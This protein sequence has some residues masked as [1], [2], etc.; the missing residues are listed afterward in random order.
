MAYQGKRH[1][2]VPVVWLCH[3]GQSSFAMM[4]ISLR[5]WRDHVQKRLFFE[6]P[7]RTLLPVTT[8]FAA[9]NDSAGARP[10]EIHT[11]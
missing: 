3:E 11:A 4:A 10:A 5:P 8:P 1:Y 2:L 7:E 9:T 6:G